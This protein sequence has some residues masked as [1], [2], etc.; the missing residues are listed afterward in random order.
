MKIKIKNSHLSAVRLCISQHSRVL[1][2]LAFSTYHAVSPR[3]MTPSLA[4]PMN[5]LILARAR[6]LLPS[7]SLAAKFPTHRWHD[8][9]SLPFGFVVVVLFHLLNQCPHVSGM[10]WKEK[11]MALYRPSVNPTHLGN[12]PEEEGKGEGE[13]P[14]LLNE[15]YPSPTWKAADIEKGSEVKRKSLS[16]VWLFATPWTIHSM[17]FSRPEYRNG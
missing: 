4:V 5:T 12:F 7:H 13:C 16:H 3:G 9:N 2:R 1:S 6:S 8:C 15:N 10:N 11:D 14:R 17:E